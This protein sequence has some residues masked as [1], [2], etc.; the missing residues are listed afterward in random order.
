VIPNRINKNISFIASTYYYSMMIQNGIAYSFGRNNFGQ[1]GLNH[2]NNILEPTE[3]LGNYTVKKIA[4][5]LDHSV[6]L[7][8]NG[9]V[10]CF[11]RNSV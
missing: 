3:I 4:L 6:I 1:L 8:T 2:L 10:Y 11:G 5:G 7:T 9:S